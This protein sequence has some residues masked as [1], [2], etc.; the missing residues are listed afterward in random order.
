[1]DQFQPNLETYNNYNLCKKIFKYFIFQ[2]PNCLCY[3]I[4]NLLNRH[5]TDNSLDGIIPTQLGNLTQLQNL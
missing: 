1:M 4:L 2:S 5:L 3:N